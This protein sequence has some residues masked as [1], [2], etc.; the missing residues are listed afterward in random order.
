M[1]SC[2]SYV[3]CFLAFYHFPIPCLFYGFLIFAFFL[4]LVEGIMR[5]ISVKLF[6]FYWNYIDFSY[7]WTHSFKH[8]LRCTFMAQFVQSS[9][10]SFVLIHINV[11][12]CFLPSQSFF[13]IVLDYLMSLNQ[14]HNTEE[15]SPV[16]FEPPI[17]WSQVN[18]SYNKRLYSPYLMLNDN[19]STTQIPTLIWAVK[20]QCDRLMHV[21][22]T[23]FIFVACDKWFLDWYRTNKQSNVKI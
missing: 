12:I 22:F 18:H 9:S 10:S 16:M 17:T 4:T 21:C 14:A 11:L 7:F 3:W 15:V 8:F 1:I 5:N 20:F 19:Q 13:S 6:Q 23:V 2:L